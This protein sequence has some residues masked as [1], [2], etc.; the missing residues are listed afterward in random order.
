MKSFKTTVQH[1]LR[2]IERLNEYIEMW[3]IFVSLKNSFPTFAYI[4]LL[5]TWMPAKWHFQLNGR[6]KVSTKS[7]YDYRTIAIHIHQYQY[8]VFVC[9]PPSLLCVCVCVCAR[10]HSLRIEL[11]SKLS[12]KWKPFQA[13]RVH[14]P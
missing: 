5:F 2:A 8:C 14:H 12:A 11:K 13:C 1:L 4:K 9:S 10:S 3:L 7:D 6:E